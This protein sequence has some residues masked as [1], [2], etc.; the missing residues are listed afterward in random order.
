[1]SRPAP[2]PLAQALSAFTEQLAPD[3]VLAKVHEAWEQAV[4]PTIAAVCRP[5]AE[6]EGALTVAC[7]EA[8]WAQ[9]LELMGETVVQR[10]NDLLGAPPLKR[11]R[12]RVG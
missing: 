11:L 5:V 3:S 4:G 6:R 12:C 9:E 10:L 8:V 1:M 2:R 7:A